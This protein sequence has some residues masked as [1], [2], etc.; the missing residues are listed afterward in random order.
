M[1]SQQIP[2]PVQSKKIRGGKFFV[3]YLIAANFFAYL[4]SAII[5]AIPRNCH[6]AWLCQSGTSFIENLHRALSFNKDFLRMLFDRP[7]LTFLFLFFLIVGSIL[8]FTNFSDKRV[9]LINNIFIFLLSIIVFLPV[10][11]VMLLYIF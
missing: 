11:L 9:Y 7:L 4:I 10:Y 3:F 6:G 1:I 8:S 5:G 2:Q